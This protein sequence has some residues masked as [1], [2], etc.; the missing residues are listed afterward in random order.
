MQIVFDH[1]KNQHSLAGA[2]AA[3]P[4]I[5]GDRYPRNMLDVGCWVGTWLRAAM[6]YGISDIC[7]LDGV[8]LDQDQLLFPP[9]LFRQQDLT[10]RWDLGRRFDCV[11]CL[12]VGEHLPPDSATTL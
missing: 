12:E 4:H 8:G 5:F 1:S 3:L 10:K 11:L 2:K 6:D 7:G 9:A